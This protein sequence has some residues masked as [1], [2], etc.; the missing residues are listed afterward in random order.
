[1]TDG[2]CVSCS[3]AAPP[4][5]QIAAGWSHTCVLKDGAARCWGDNSYGQLGLAA[6]ASAGANNIVGDQPGEVAALAAID[7]GAGLAPA[8]IVAGGRHTCALLDDGEVKCWGANDSGQLGLG[9]FLNRGDDPR[10]MGDDLPSIDLGD[11]VTVKALSAGGRHTCALLMDGQVKCW[12]A[13]DSGQLGLGDRENRGDDPCEMGVFLSPVDLDGAAAVAL[14]AGDAYTCALLDT[15]VVRCWGANDSGQLGLGDFMNSGDGSAPGPPPAVPFPA[16]GASF[17]ALAAGSTHA[18]ALT[19]DG[20]ATCFGLNRAGQIGIESSA[21]VVTP[22]KDAVH[23]DDTIV[24]LTAGADHTCALLDSG[25]VKCWGFN[26]YGQLGIGATDN[27]GG[28]PNQM[29]ALPTVNLGGQPMAPALSI[30]A[31]GDHTCA[32]LESHAVKCW[33]LNAHGELGIGSTAA[34]LGGKPSD[35][36]PD[37]PLN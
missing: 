33:G 19:S 6:P 8:A 15:G 1:V 32:V 9:D 21:A 7:L 10:E 31:G 14:V 13:N 3:T 4:A 11:M 24:Q 37:V 29:R 28:A 25:G 23:L 5:P 36:L 18:C 12:G 17:L 30:A 34:S 35:M 26:L 27:R 22:P 20:R 2:D 16:A